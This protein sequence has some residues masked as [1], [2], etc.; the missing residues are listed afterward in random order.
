VND[1]NSHREITFNRTDESM[2]RH[3]WRITDFS[4]SE[5]RV[6]AYWD[7]LGIV[8]SIH[9]FK[10]VRFREMPEC[11]DGLASAIVKCTDRDERLMVA[12]VE[13]LLSFSK[14]MGLRL[15]KSRK[16]GQRKKD[17]L[18]LIHISFSGIFPLDIAGLT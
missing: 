11:R 17:T 10:L 1:P 14:K 12:E 4:G 3:R 6:H 13:F 7:L 2:L 15:R 5:E 16:D 8:D 9:C 18:I